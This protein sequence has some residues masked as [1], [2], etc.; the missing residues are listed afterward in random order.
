M[1]LA[2]TSLP[3]PKDWQDFER[4]TKVLFEYILS[5][6]NTQLNGRSGQPQKGVDIIGQRNECSW[7]GVQCKKKYKQKISDTELRSEVNKAKNFNPPITEFY[8]VTTAERDQAIQETARL[9]TEELSHTN[10]PIKVYVWGWD[11]IEENASKYDKA[12]E[13]FDPTWNPYVEKG[14]NKISEDNKRNKEMLDQIYSIVS[15]TYNNNNIKNDDKNEKTQLHG[16]ITI[17]QQLINGGDVEPALEQLLKLRNENWEKASASERYRILTSIASANHKL[18]QGEKA[19]RLLIEAYKEYP[20]HIDAPQNLAVGYLLVNDVENAARFTETAIKKGSLNPHFAN[21]LIQ[22]R[23]KD[24]NCDNP[25][26]NIPE[27]LHET[28]EVLIALCHFHR[29]RGNIDWVFIAKSAKDKY[30]KSNILKILYAEGIL[31]MVIRTEQD[32]T[33]GS[34]FRKVSIEEFN[35]AVEILYSEAIKAIK[36]YSEFLT[37]IVF[38]AALALRLKNDC[39][40]AKEILDKAIEKYPG[41]EDLCLQR[42]IIAYME[43]NPE[44]VLKFLPKDSENPEVVSLRVGALIDTNIDSAIALLE[45]IDE[46]NFPEQIKIGFLTDRLALY[47]KTDNKQKAIDIISR[48]LELEPDNLYFR[49]LE[50][51]TY[52]LI[53][54]KQKTEDSFNRAFS[55]VSESTNLHLRIELSFEAERLNREYEI[56]ELLNNRV[57]TTRDN[58]GLQILVTA[59]LNT[60]RWYTCREILNSIPLEMKSINWIQRAEVTLALNT[61]DI[62]AKEKVDEYLERHPQDLNIILARVGIYQREGTEEEIKNY[63]QNIDFDKLEGTPEQHIRFAAI[64]SHY[65]DALKGLNYSYSILMNNWTVPQVHLAY[66]SLILLNDKIETFLSSSD[67]IKENTVVGVVSENKEQRYRLENT[68]YTFY[69]EERVDSRNRLYSLLIGKKIGE[70]IYIHNYIGSK[71]VKI[72]WIKSKYIDALHRSFEYFNERFPNTEG[73]MLFNTNADSNDPLEDIREVMKAR[74]ENSMHL[75]EEYSIKRIPLAFVAKLSGNDLIDT[76][77]GLGVHNYKFLVCNGSAIEIE[78]AQKVI[79]SY[80]RQGCVLDVITLSLIRRLGIEEVVTSICGQMFIPQSVM[81]Y[82]TTRYMIENQNKGKQKGFMAW[83]NNQLIVKNYSQDYLSELVAERESELIWAKKNTKIA[84]S[85]PKFDLSKEDILLREKLGNDICDIIFAASGNNYILLSED[86]G[87]RMWASTAFNIQAIWLQP[88]LMTALDKGYIT[89]E[90][91]YDLVNKLVFLGHTFVTLNSDCLMYQARKDNFIVT[92]ELSE[93]LKMV[94]GIN[95]HFI[96]NT[97]VLGEFINKILIECFDQFKIKRILSEILSSFS[98]GRK[99][100]LRTI[101]YYITFGVFSNIT[102]IYRYSLEWLIGHSIGMPYFNELLQ[103]KL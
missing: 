90:K 96:T 45:N 13:A 32:A 6:P 46:S 5:D 43:R 56:V 83:Q 23:I 100:D 11:D 86:L 35:N 80:N 40:R 82:L 34:E 51:K 52:R 71:P 36:E 74:A 67:V 48:K 73:A 26:N 79:N 4:K 78:A 60:C 25:L 20:E 49:I 62:S 31:D 85:I 70:E 75:L 17:L 42:S 69:E 57:S 93:L 101:V 55:L 24:I 61:G 12:W 98:S 50:I 7:V 37:S 89:N 8:M 64:I 97:R 66:Q 19:G 63:I 95:A 76:W 94:G 28:E 14:F 91:Y 87:Y 103:I 102:S 30:P 81:N 1:S 77:R 92:N 18:G 99:E 22:A 10:N 16:K 59:L 15:S 33:S 9:I 68:K 54:D 53:G 47:I 72:R 65:E 3:K 88:I 41:N 84:S 38:N 2:D 44:E 21:L 29:Q 58:D 39:V 27:K